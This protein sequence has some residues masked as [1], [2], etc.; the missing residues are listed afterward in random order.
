[1]PGEREVRRA[2]R[3]TLIRRQRRE[4]FM[5]AVRRREVENTEAA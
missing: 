2:E 1:M 5:E 4:Q 3:A